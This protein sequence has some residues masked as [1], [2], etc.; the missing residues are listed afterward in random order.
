MEDWNSIRENELEAMKR[1]LESALS[2]GAL[3][4]STGLI[5]PPGCYAELAEIIE[6]AKVSA[7]QGGVYV[8]H[9][10][11]EREGLEQAIAEALQIGSDARIDVLISHLKAAE[12]PNWGKIPGILNSLEKHNQQSGRKPSHL[13]NGCFES[14]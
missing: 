12:K 7:A 10:R 11:N 5:Y 8:S 13:A 4:L 6:L 14:K 1:S 3:G 9:I 2:Q